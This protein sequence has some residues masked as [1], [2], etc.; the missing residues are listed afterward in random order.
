MNRAITTRIDIKT[1]Y[2][3]TQLASVQA[4]R[5]SGKELASPRLSTKNLGNT[6]R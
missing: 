6:G 3:S 2:A 5:T 4:Y 1:L